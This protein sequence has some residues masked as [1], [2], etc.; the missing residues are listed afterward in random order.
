M[1]NEPT[2][3]NA[4][5]TATIELVL[6]GEP[7]QMQ[8]TVPTG[9][10]TPGQLLHLL[11][12]LTDAVVDSAVEKSTAQ[13]NPI[14]CRKGC[15]AC[16]RQL[17]PIAPAEAHRLRQVVDAM[18]EPRRSEVL[19]RFEAA[20]A[21]LAASGML[22]RLRA[23]ARMDETSRRQLGIDYFRNGVACPF[24]EQE[25]CSIYAERPLACREYL[26]TSPT[27][28]CAQPTPD[29]IDCLPIAAR[30][31][32]ALWQLEAKQDHDGLSWVPLITALEW[33]QTHPEAPPGASGPAQ[34]E[35]LFKL[36]GAAPA[37]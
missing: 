29:S 37:T 8:L 11:R 17:V 21:K 6:D 15:G 27:E 5:V 18:P 34:I 2:Q 10:A 31:S 20:R 19:A 1:A 32:R 25:S 14:S 16:C 9:P 12:G 22:E 13:G 4:S 24:L 30:V 33:A 28:H 36:L 26:V 7:L 35:S 23:P 3:Q